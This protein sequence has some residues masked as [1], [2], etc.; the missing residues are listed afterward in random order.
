MTSKDELWGWFS[1]KMSPVFKA[2]S[3]GSTAVWWKFEGMLHQGVCA[4]KAE[5]LWTRQISDTNRMSNILRRDPMENLEDDVLRD[6][7]PVQAQQ[8]VCNM[9][10]ASKFTD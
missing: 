8:H 7:Q 1:D 2:N 3:K 6:A 10:E 9:I 4:S 5:S